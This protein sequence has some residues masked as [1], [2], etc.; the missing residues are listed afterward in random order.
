M[1]ATVIP[2]LIKNYKVDPNYITATG[3]SAGGQNSFNCLA[4]KTCSASLQMV[5]A[6]RCLVASVVIKTPR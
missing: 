6:C 2:W 4:D 3:L 5:C 1:D